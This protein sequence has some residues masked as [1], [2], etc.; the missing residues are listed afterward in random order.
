M[1]TFRLGLHWLYYKVDAN[2]LI[3]NVWKTN[4]PKTLFWWNIGVAVTMFVEIGFN[5]LV[6]F[7]LID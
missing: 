5:S 3:I 6:V 1:L 2:E 7:Y 4:S